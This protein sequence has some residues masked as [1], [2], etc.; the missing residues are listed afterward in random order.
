MS[1]V[2]PEK[3]PE[4]KFEIKYLTNNYCSHYVM[5]RIRPEKTLTEE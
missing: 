1:G 2:C 5:T 3:I 4:G